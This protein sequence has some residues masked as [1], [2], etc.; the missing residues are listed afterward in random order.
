MLIQEDSNTALYQIQRYEPGCIWINQQCYRH[1]IILRPSLLLSWDPP[2]I[3][4]LEENDLA[5]LLEDPPNILLLGTGPHFS[6][7]PF[8]L[9]VALQR[10]AIGIEYMDSRRACFVYLAL[11]SEQ[12]NVAACIVV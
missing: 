2:P 5:P 4:S 10:R 1:S 3:D 12:R 8:S 7:P 11:S 6:L 9:L